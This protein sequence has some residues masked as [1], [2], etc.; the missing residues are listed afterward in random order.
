MEKATENASI[1]LCSTTMPQ[2]PSIY[3]VDDGGG[4]FKSANLTVSRCL[5]SHR[6]F[7]A[8]CRANTIATPPQDASNSDSEEVIV[9]YYNDTLGSI[10]DGGGLR[11]EMASSAPQHLLT[12]CCIAF[13]IL[14]LHS[15]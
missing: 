8:I 7:H 1:D 9:E 5:P 12:R 15:V 11:I 14:S 4:S 2:A 3:P 6:S 13:V 10:M